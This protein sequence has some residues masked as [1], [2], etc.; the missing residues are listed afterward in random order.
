[1]TLS[2]NKELL[3]EKTGENLYFRLFL[4]KRQLVNFALV[5]HGTH[6]K[7][8]HIFTQPVLNDDQCYLMKRIGLTRGEK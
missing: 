1:M 8:V 3:N 5:K 7:S 2:V 6:N 4:R